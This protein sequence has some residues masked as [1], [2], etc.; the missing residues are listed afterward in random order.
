MEL[1]VSELI[2]SG[3]NIL[4]DKGLPFLDPSWGWHGLA[5]KGDGICLIQMS[6]LLKRHVFLSFPCVY[7]GT[8]KIHITCII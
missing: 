6:E 8:E 4:V 5:P 7:S 3:L 2:I 1:S